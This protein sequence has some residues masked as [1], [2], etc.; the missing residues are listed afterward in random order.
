MLASLRLTLHQQ[1]AS[2]S[3]PVCYYAISSG[4]SG[5]ITLYGQNR[6]AAHCQLLRRSA[7]QTTA[8]RIALYGACHYEDLGHHGRPDARRVRRRVDTATTRRKR[9][10]FAELST[11]FARYENGLK[12]R[13][14]RLGTKVAISPPVVKPAQDPYYCATMQTHWPCASSVGGPEH[15]DSWLFGGTRSSSASACWPERVPRH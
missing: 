5:P 6:V 13:S 8:S 11:V 12:K 7:V 14:E 2:K 4:D 9:A 10:Q 3:R 15:D 1:W